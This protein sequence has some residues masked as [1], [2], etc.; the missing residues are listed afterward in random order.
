MSEH[1]AA[2]RGADE[3]ETGADLPRSGRHELGHPAVTEHEIGRRRYLV[4]QVE[5]LDV[6]GVRTLAIGSG[7]WAV[8]V[9]AM[10]PFVGSLR[11]HDRLGWLWTAIAGLGLGLL[12]LAYCRHR[13]SALKRT[14]SRGRLEDGYL[15]AADH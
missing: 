11:E 3:P 5:P 14:P 12:G 7:V 2:A 4:A 6:D 15:D 13:R 10:L 8:A 1:G 9:L